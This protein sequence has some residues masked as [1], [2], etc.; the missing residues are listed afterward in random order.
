MLR[1]CALVLGCLLLA[2]CASL[3]RK[4]PA[5][6]GL[7]PK[8][9]ATTTTASSALVVGWI[10]GI[11][12]SSKSVLVEVGSFTVLPSDFATRI[13]I[14]RTDDLRPA[15]RLQSSSF[16]RGRILGTRLITGSPQVG[17]EVVC[18]PANP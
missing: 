14:A 6:A 7:T 8:V 9:S 17:D 3:G 4:A 13:L 16:L 11:D 12:P 1:A 15:A 10:I 2:G 18:A 5:D